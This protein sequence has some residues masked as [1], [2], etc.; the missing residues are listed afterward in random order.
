MSERTKTFTYL[1]YPG[2][3]CAE[4]GEP[5]VDYRPHVGVE[6]V[7]NLGLLCGDKLGWK[8]YYL[9]PKEKERNNKLLLVSDVVLT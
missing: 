9:M 5:R 2:K 4:G 1:S 6:M 8:L 7:N 3:V